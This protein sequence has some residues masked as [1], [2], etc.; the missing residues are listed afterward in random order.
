MGKASAIFFS[1]FLGCLML[2]P[3]ATAEV[4]TT[5]VEI[6]SPTSITVDGLVVSGFAEPGEET[7]GRV[8]DPDCNDGRWDPYDFWRLNVSVG[9]RFA[10][11]FDALNEPDWV[12]LRVELCFLDLQFHLDYHCRFWFE[13]EDNLNTVSV[14]AE[15]DNVYGEDALRI[16]PIDGSGGEDSR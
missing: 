14:S 12:G 6:S 16:V 5:N 2:S 7:V 1:L 8:C 15:T 3:L 11:S 9:A 13:T 4:T 10:L